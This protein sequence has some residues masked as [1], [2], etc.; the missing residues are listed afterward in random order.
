MDSLATDVYAYV[1]HTVYVQ[2]SSTVLFSTN[3]CTSY[4]VL[5]YCGVE[6]AEVATVH[7]KSTS[8]TTSA[9]YWS[10]KS[11]ILYTTQIAVP[12]CLELVALGSFLEQMHIYICMCTDIHNPHSV[13]HCWRV[14]IGYL[15]LAVYY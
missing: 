1:F 2:Y 7:S 6:K 3:T 13:F 14:A 5:E 11:H 12:N 8:S 15:R 10:T 4:L 9:L